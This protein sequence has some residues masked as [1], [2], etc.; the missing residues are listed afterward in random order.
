VVLINL[1][2]ATHG[3]A[4]YFRHAVAKHVFKKIDDII[5]WRVVSLLRERHHWEWKD[6]RRRRGIP[7]PRH[8][9]LQ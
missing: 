1:N 3:W 6:V 5:W 2:R 4:S 7:A 8:R 9:R